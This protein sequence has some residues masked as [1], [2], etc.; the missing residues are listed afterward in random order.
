[1][2][3]YV[4]LSVHSVLRPLSLLRPPV[5]VKLVEYVAVGAQGP[6][7]DAG[8]E[9]LVHAV[10]DCNGRHSDSGVTQTLSHCCTLLSKLTRSKSAQMRI[11]FTQTSTTYLDSGVQVLLILGWLDRDWT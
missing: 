7:C 8:P 9:G 3:L 6:S 10:L 5:Q 1:M 11:Q 4:L 2:S